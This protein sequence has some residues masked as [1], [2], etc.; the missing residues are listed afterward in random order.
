MVYKYSIFTRL[1]RV[2]LF[3]MQTLFVNI[4]EEISLHIFTVTE[5]LVM[6]KTQRITLSQ[7]TCQLP[8]ISF[9]QLK[10]G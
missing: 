4:N 8:L 3:L 5:E 9:F 7:Q 2:L 6:N 1:P 10:C